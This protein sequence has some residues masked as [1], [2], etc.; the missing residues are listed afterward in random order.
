MAAFA[1]A[2]FASS[3][4]K[5]D[6]PASSLT[7]MTFSVDG[8]GLGLSVTKA[9][10]VTAL[11]SVYWSATTGD[12]GNDTEI[13]APVS[14]SVS[15]NNVSTGNYWPAESI[16][17]NYYVSNVAYTWDAGSQGAVIAASN[18]TDIVAGLAEASYKSS[19][20][21]TLE[22]IF[23]RTGSLTLEPHAGYTL[24]DVVVW[25]IKSNADAGVSGTYNIGAKTWSGVGALEQREFSSSSDLYL[26]PGSY[27][28]EITYTLKKDSFVQE[29][30]KNA[31]VVLE[32]G[33]VNNIR[34]TAHTG[35]EEPSE[36]SLSIELEPWGE[37]NITIPEGE[38]I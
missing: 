30:T 19:P 34:A 1:F 36:I 31:D 9:E 3:C 33:A 5:I 17:Y 13:Y 12:I 20:K 4:N 24:G 10:A 23:A 8:G 38:L 21:V 29:Y 11:T 16:A 35:G 32:G 14:L 15:E 27:N 37:H 6:V 22:H 2:L 7:E 25:K 18:G 26:V 28:V